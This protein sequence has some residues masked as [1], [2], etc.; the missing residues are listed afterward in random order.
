MREIPPPNWVLRTAIGPAS[1]ARQL[2]VR[3]TSG[4]HRFA[5]LSQF[6]IETFWGFPEGRMSN[7]RVDG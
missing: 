3:S 2:A 6:A 7:L 1:M 5:K 4:L